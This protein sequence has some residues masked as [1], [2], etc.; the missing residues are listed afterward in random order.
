MLRSLI[1]SSYSS[2]SLLLRRQQLRRRNNDVSYLISRSFYYLNDGKHNNDDSNNNNATINNDD[3]DDNSDENNNNSNNNNNGDNNNNDNNN[4]L[5]S[6]G[7]GDNAPRYPQLLGLPIVSRPLFPSI[8]TSLIVKDAATIHALEGLVSSGSGYLGTFLRKT[9]SNGIT[10]NGMILDTP[11]VITSAQDLYK[12]GTF[13]QI[14]KMTKMEDPL[15][16][17]STNSSSTM[18]G[19]MMGNNINNDD[20]NHDEEEEGSDLKKPVVSLW[21]TGHRRIDLTSVNELGPPVELTVSHWD[22]LLVQDERTII[23]RDADAADANNHSVRALTNEVISVIR[24]VAQMNALF[25]E[26]LSWFLPTIR[27]NAGDN[28][29]LSSDAYRVADFVAS[30]SRSASPAGLQAVLE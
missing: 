23:D 19:L 6:S 21:L 9:H 1:A 18:E 27:S 11:E 13:C 20:E 10:D 17:S 29:F 12:V 26:S 5:T 25:R 8:P 2:S 24:E 28:L 4:L 15:F 3:N 16:T 7:T 30:L 14:L 22:R